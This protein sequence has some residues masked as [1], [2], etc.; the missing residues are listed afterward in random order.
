MKTT[1]AIASAAVIMAASMPG[2][3][4]HGYIYVPQSQFFGGE[5]SQWSVQIPPVWPS[6]D[7]YGNTQKSV[8]VFNSLKTSHN[9]KDLRTLLDNTAVYGP[10]CGYTNPNGTPQ[11]IPTNGKAIF[12]RGLIHTGPCEIWLDDKKVM[13]ADDCYSKYGH[14]N[15]N[16]KTEFPVDYSY[17]KAKGG[18]MMRFYWLGFQALGKKTVWQTYKNCI[19]LKA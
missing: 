1:A 15:V 2:A 5:N 16:V 17:C 13:A 4:A 7:W 18:C 10:N 12:S 19:P 6:N 14:S 11:P 9:Y 3:D 8:Q